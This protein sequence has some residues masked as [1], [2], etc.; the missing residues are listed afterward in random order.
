MNLGRKGDQV[1]VSYYLFE[2]HLNYSIPIGNPKLS[3]EVS[4]K[5]ETKNLI[6]TFRILKSY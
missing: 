6:F 1:E 5:P 3:K 2:A 4:A